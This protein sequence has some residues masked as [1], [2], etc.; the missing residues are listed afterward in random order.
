MKKGRFGRRS[1]V[2][3]DLEDVVDGPRLIR[4]IIPG[5]FGSLVHEQIVFEGGEGEVVQSL[6]LPAGKPPH[7]D[8][9]FRA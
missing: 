5:V 8:F 6:V 4:Q 3:P 9:S 2:L 7:A 1:F